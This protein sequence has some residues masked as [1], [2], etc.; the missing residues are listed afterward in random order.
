M[1]LGRLTR[2]DLA[3]Y[4]AVGIPAEKMIALSLTLLDGE[5]ERAS[6]HLSLAL[7]AFRKAAALEA[8]LPYTERPF[9]ISR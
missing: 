9:G 4:E 7:G 5:I 8:A 2:A 1:D 6:G 3:R